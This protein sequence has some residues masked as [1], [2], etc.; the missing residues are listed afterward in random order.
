VKMT[1]RMLFCLAVVLAFSAP[2]VAQS[3]PQTGPS[4][5]DVARKN[6]AE[7]KKSKIV[8]TEDDIPASNA[9]TMEAAPAAAAA[10][11]TP[12]DATAPAAAP[13]AAETPAAEPS[14]TEKALARAR[15]AEAN[16]QAFLQR[17]EEGGVEV[18]TDA[19]RKSVQTAITN[20]QQKLDKLRARRESLERAAQAE[21]QNPPAEQ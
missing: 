12:T 21:A 5:A 16:Q 18:S 17:L 6:K 4:L 8:V 20:A 7:K 1:L 9:T 19:E 11:A 14:A 15:S 3:E 10:E 2:V 13:A